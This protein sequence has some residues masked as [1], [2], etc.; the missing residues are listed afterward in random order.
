[1][2]ANP[3]NSKKNKKQQQQQPLIDHRLSESS[4]SVWTKLELDFGEESRR[5]V[6]VIIRTR[7]MNKDDYCLSRTI[8]LQASVMHAL[9]I[10]SSFIIWWWRR[11]GAW[12]PWSTG[13]GA[14]GESPHQSAMIDGASDS[15]AIV[16][17]NLLACLLSCVC[18]CS[19]SPS[20]FMNG[21][22]DQNKIKSFKSRFKKPHMLESQFYKPN[23][24]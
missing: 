3:K 15:C 14:R 22:L 6:K 2:Q 9:L 21:L 4:Q 17:H 12:A 7:W 16:F 11:N 5:R 1:M 20:L 8:C 24:L 19:S 18:V 10:P 13:L 23:S